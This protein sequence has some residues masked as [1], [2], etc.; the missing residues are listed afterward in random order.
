MLVVN[1]QEEWDAFLYQTDTK[2]GS[3]YKLNKCLLNKQTAVH[4]LIGP[5]V[6]SG[7]LG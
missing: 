5:N 6:W 7:V 2:N 4:S 1:K 3:V